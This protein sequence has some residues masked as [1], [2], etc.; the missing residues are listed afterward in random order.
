MNVS[1]EIVRCLGPL[2]SDSLQTSES[3]RVVMARVLNQLVIVLG[4]ASKVLRQNT[5]T[6]RLIAAAKIS[7]RRS[8]QD[9]NLNRA[10]D[11]LAHLVSGIQAVE[12]SSGLHCLKRPLIVC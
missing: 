4:L 2:A 5:H 3:V 7:E 8:T 10:L 12:A 1:K 9:V 6:L 11:D